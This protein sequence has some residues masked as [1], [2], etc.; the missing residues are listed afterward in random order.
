[1]SNQYLK[2]RRSGVP[3]KI[4]TTES[5]DFG[6]IALNTYDGLAYMKKSGS[7]G[8]EVVPIGLSSGS[9]S[10]SFRG[11]FTGSLQ[12][13]ASWAQNYNE[14]DPVFTAV[15]GTFATTASFNAFTSSYNTGSF[16]GSFTGSLLGTAATASYV[17]N[18]QTASYVVL[19]Q[20]ASYI[21]QAQSASYAST[22]SYVLNAVSA[23]YSNTASYVELAQTASYVLNA[24]SASYA[25]SS[26]YAVNATNAATASNILGGKAPHIPYF[27]TDTTLATSSLYQSGS[28]TVIINQD[29]A[30][31]ANPEALYVWQPSTSSINVISGKGNLDNYL[32]L[33]I[34]NTNQGP[35]ASSDVVATANNGSELDNYIDMGIN[36]QNYAGFLGD[37]NDSYLYSHGHDMW[38]GNIN[39]G[40]NLHLFNSSSINPLVTI[41]P[42]NDVDVNTRLNAPNLTGSLEGTAS[43]AKNII[44]SSHA[45]NSDFAGY[46]QTAGI[47]ANGGVTQLIAGS[48]V[49]LIPSTG[50]GNVTVIA[51]GVGGVT[52][53]SGSNVTQSFSNSN[54]WNFTHNLGVRT[55]IINV[56]DSNY[57]QVIPE[58]IQLIDTASAIITFPTLESG[59][60]IASV[61]G[62][63][64]NALSSS[65]SLLATYADT[66]S[67]Y[68]E[69]DPIFVAKSASLA[70]TGS[71]IF[72][73]TQTISGSMILVNGAT[74]SLL[75]TASFATTAS[76]TLN[77]LSASYAQTA[78]YS[79]NL[80]VSGSIS[81]VDY[82]DFNTTTNPSH[83]EGRVHWDDTV[84]TLQLDTESPNFSIDVGHQN[85]VRVY[86]N[87]GADIQAGKI[88]YINGAQGNT[89][90]VATASWEIDPSSAST[91]GFAATTISGSGGNRH[92][93]VITNGLI[94]NINTNG[95]AVG[96]RLFL[97]SSGTFTDV[98]PDAPLHEVRLGVVVVNNA[99]TGVIYVNIVNG[100][101]LTELHDV[102]TTSESN[103][104][105]LVYSAS[106][107]TNSKALTGSYSVTGSLTISGS[108]T[109]TNIGPAVFTGSVGISG[110]VSMA[111]SIIPAVSSSFS[112]GSATNPWKDIFVKSG[113]ISIESD[114]PGNP[115]TLISNVG[116]NILLSAGGKLSTAKAGKEMIKRA[117]GSYSQRGLWDNIRAAAKRNKAAGKAGKKPTA[118]MLKQEKKIK[119]KSK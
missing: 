84:K 19:A 3:G 52:I 26:S 92:G 39:D 41:T 106:L 5:I 15:S 9:F 44:S 73:G 69:T 80:V 116:G 75:G 1:M 61:G 50:V 4:P 36:S 109:F 101:E 7:S 89:P 20:T 97:S 56:F 113:S 99:T 46:A 76:Y 49:S 66:A 10:G 43:W 95:I 91:I 37:A 98:A 38:I 118:A 13:T 47:A 58:S 21:Q 112:L 103:G 33:N 65:Y 100:F 23:S 2:L 16:T 105:L 45:I 12:G 86:N 27:I 40:Y 83:L 71:N 93:Y 28:S 74:G 108:S 35:N 110:S 60:A 6:E 57:N 88:V 78:S 62:V 22:A 104:D 25:L 68:A 29:A 8:I 34:Q 17:K 107:W 59:F 18:A 30:T 117:D 115:S 32:Q 119:A 54:T 24:V 87:T 82:I 81:T 42:S 85:V 55:P 72:R 77:A 96:S 70:T 114:V 11:T 111:G 14:T 51:T 94:T 63:T 48:G 53:L 67:Y 102:R 79:Q 31:E 64:G 90:T